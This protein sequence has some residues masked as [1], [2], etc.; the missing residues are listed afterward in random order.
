MLCYVTLLTVQICGYNP[1]K[2]WPHDIAVGRLIVLPR[3]FYLSSFLFVS[4]PSS[5]LNGTQ[6]KPDTCSDVSVCL[7]HGVY[8]FP[9]NRGPNNH[10]LQRL[11]NLTANLTAYIF[12]IKYD[13]HNRANA[14]ETTRSLLHRLKMSWTL[15]H[16]RLKIGPKFSAFYFIATLHSRTSANR[17]QPSFA[18]RW[19]VNRDNNLP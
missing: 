1:H 17:T 16:K 13:I 7:K 15:V 12:W 4:Y 19:T 5:S 14:L 18:K 2:I 3:F 11:P 10:I 8:P 9:K 6:P